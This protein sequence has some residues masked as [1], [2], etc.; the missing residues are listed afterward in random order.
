MHCPKCGSQN[1]EFISNTQSK[2]RGLG[3]WLFWIIIWFVTFGIGFIFWV[4]MIMTNKKT[5]T[6]TRAICRNCGHQ[7][8]V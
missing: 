2:N 1:I 4:V 8:D 7:W 5:L 3:S 6:K